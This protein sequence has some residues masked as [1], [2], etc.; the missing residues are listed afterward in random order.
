MLRVKG[1]KETQEIEQSAGQGA[2][3]LGLHTV[4]QHTCMPNT[5]AHKIKMYL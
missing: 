3:G 5:H 1:R 2:V 4:Q